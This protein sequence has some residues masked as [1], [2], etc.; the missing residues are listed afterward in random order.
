MENKF[1][2]FDV[3]KVNLG[4]NHF[5]IGS[6]TSIISKDDKYCYNVSGSPIFRQ[7]EDLEDYNLSMIKKLERKDNAPSEKDPDNIK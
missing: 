6:I 1:K 3:V 4:T 5:L 7:E 2:L